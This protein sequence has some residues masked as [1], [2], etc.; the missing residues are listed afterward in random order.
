M[1]RQ[2]LGRGRRERGGGSEIEDEDEKAKVEGSGGCRGGGIL[3]GG[4]RYKVC[5]GGCEDTQ[6]ENYFCFP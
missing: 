5:S 6:L 2:R 3:E 1:F 4:R